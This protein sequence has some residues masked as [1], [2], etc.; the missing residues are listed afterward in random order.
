M[1]VSAMVCVSTP[2]GSHYIQRLCKHWTHKFQVECTE[3]RGCIFLLG[4][5]CARLLA[6][7]E[8]LNVG[9]EASDIEGLERMQGVIETHLRRLAYKEDLQIF[10]WR[11]LGETSMNAALSNQALRYP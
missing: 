11:L 4:G 6:D 10:A 9:L 8:T 1:T 5:A 3:W 7:A 2:H